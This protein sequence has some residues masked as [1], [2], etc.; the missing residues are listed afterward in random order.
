LITFLTDALLN[1]WN[2]EYNC[3]Q[4]CDAVY[5]DGNLTADVA[6]EHAAFMFNTEVQNWY[7]TTR[8]RSITA[9]KG[10]GANL[11]QQRKLFFDPT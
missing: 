11:L 6:E 5:S 1:R 8:L 10:D 7:L 9:Q 2:S 4:V 3:L